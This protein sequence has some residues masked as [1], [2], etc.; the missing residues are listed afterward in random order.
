MAN[1]RGKSRNSDRF[2][3]LG[4]LNHCRWWLQPWNSKT[5]DP[6]NK[7]YDKPRQDISKQKYHF[8]KKCPDSQSMVFSVVMYRCETWTVKKAEHPKIDAFELWCW[9]RL[10]RVPWTKEPGGLQSVGSQRIEH[11]QPTL[12]SIHDYWK[13]ES[14]DQ[15]NLLSV[16]WYLCFLIHC[17]VMS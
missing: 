11:F 17:L 15:M 6:W 12:T 16:K 7:S 1:R 13:N 14:L 10:L 3:F 5:L 2:Y 9:R 4:L 8:A